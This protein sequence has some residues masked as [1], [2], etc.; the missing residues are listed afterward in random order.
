VPTGIADMNGDG[1][2]DIISVNRGTDLLIQYQ[3]PDPARPFVYYEFPVELDANEQNDI[4]IADFNNDGFNDIMTVGSYDRVKVLY[5]IPYTY[6]YNVTHVVVTHLLTRG[7]NRRFHH[8]GWVDVV[9]LNDNGLNYTLLNDGK[10]PAGRISCFVIV[11]PSDNSGNYGSVYTDFDMDGDLDFTSPN[12]A[13]VLIV[14]QS[15]V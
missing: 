10:G 12:V 5:N 13:R 15:S 9:M 11:P 3:T 7:F 14:R 4:C 6:G 2:D 1:L 8:D